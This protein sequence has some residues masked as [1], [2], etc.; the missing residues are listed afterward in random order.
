MFFFYSLSVEEEEED[1][2]MLETKPGPESEQL[3]EDDKEIK[4]GTR[5]M[6][7][8]TGTVKTV[9]VWYYHRTDPH[10]TSFFT[11]HIHLFYKAVQPPSH[12]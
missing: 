1:E 9:L 2:E 4:E 7:E 11:T 12:I 8:G 6:Y 5:W 10:Q 3:D